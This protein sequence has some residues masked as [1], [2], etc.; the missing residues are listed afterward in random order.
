MFIAHCS[1]GINK[2]GHSAL[3]LKGQVIV[4]D[5]LEWNWNQYV[6]QLALVPSGAAYPVSRQ[7]IEVYWQLNKLVYQIPDKIPGYDWNSLKDCDFITRKCI[8]MYIYIFIYKY[9]YTYVCFW[10][11]TIYIWSHWHKDACIYIMSITKQYAPW[12]R[13]LKRISPRI[14]IKIIWNRYLYLCSLTN[15]AY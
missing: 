14:D 10:R 11:K 13:T 5:P 6:D 12:Y 2:G 3:F 15:S 8:Y 9:I 7:Y 1:E 4:W